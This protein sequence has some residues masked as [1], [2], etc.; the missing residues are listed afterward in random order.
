[1]T[2]KIGH[3][4]AELLTNL[5]KELASEL[6]LHYEDDDFFALAPTIDTMKQVAVLLEENGFRPPT[7]YEHVLRRFNRHRN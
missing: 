6:D 3:E 2:D 1:M 4:T 5:L 7:V